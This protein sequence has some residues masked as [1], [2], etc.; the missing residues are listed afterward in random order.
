ML[1]DTCEHA[2]VRTAM[3]HVYVSDVDETYQR[4]LAAGATSEREP[5]NQFY[6][7]RS[8]SVIDPF[9]INWHIATQV[10]DLSEEEFQKRLDEMMSK[11]E[12]R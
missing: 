1:A 11:G 6:G 8:A 7:D 12:Q 10:E 5:K 3:L 9:G 2:P 4:A